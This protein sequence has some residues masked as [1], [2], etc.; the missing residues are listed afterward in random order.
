MRQSCSLKTLKSWTHNKDQMFQHALFMHPSA[1]FPC[2]QNTS[3]FLPFK[4]AHST[5]WKTECRFSLLPPSPGSAGRSAGVP[6]S[7]AVISSW[8]STKWKPTQ[9]SSLLRSCTLCSAQHRYSATLTRMHAH[10]VHVHASL[11][12]S[13]SA[14]AAVCNHQQYSAWIWL[15]NATDRR[16]RSLNKNLFSSIKKQGAICSSA[17]GGIEETKS[18]KLMAPQ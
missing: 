9:S 15:W 3:I 4:L 16:K 6:A 11:H 2:P 18:A 14:R 13:S 7:A 17:G 5:P 10:N 1:C 8:S 12:T